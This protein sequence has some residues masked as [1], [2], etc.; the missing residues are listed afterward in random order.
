[1]GQADNLFSSTEAYKLREALKEFGKIYGV[2]DANTF[3]QILLRGTQGGVDVSNPNSQGLSESASQTGG[4]L[5]E[6]AD[7]I[8]SLQ[9]D[10]VFVERMIRIFE[11]F[12]AGE[13]GDELADH[14]KNAPTEDNPATISITAP[15]PTGLEGRGYI[16]DRSVSEI[17]GKPSFPEDNKIALIE[18]HHPCLLYTSD[19]ADDLLV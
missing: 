19:A 16:R 18:M 12:I 3:M 5:E 9:G 15:N 17:M 13:G 2:K 6:I 14:F 7:A 1:M 4:A 8:L 10:G 11:D